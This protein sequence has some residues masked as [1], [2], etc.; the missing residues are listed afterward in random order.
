MQGLKMLSIVFAALATILSIARAESSINSSFVYNTGR[1]GSLA[2]AVVPVQYDG[3]LYFHLEVPAEYSWVAIGTGDQM[4]GSLMWV[5][6]RSRNGTGVTLSPR[7]VNGHVE[8]SYSSSINC[9]IL[10]S[11][12]APN[13]IV[14][15]NNGHDILAVNAI[16]HNI[17]TSHSPTAD[18]GEASVNLTSTTQPFIFAL[19]PTDRKIQSD[20]K[21]AG[22]RRHVLYGQF[23]MDLSKTAL[24]DS[25][26]IDEV[27]T[28]LSSVGNWQ[29]SN[30]QLVGDVTRDHDWAP[31][32]HGAFMCVTFV[33]V[34]PLG[35]VL[36]R[37][38]ERVKWHAWVQTFGVVLVV[39]G[40]GVGVYLGMQY[41]HSK[42]FN[43]AHQVI[44]IIVVVF[45]FV[46]LSIG[47]VHHRLYGRHGQ[48][49]AL[50]RIHR[51]VGPLVL[52]LGAVNGFLGFDFADD[53][54]HNV[55]YGVIV[56]VVFV[57]LVAALLWARRRRKVKDAVMERGDS[58]GEGA[59]VHGESGR[60]V[61]RGIPLKIFG[62]N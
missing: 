23:A 5:A 39:V 35:V 49:T 51:Y 29:N 53:G 26:P 45:T 21:T 55:W 32:T 60:G 20:S 14:K 22:I 36:L 7:T 54:G 62:R 52:I 31:A 28:Q 10:T 48:S 3:S 11:N 6:Y 47:V 12:T 37:L 33:L 16:C 42:N 34:F 1:T 40:L 8:P 19:G 57:A 61:G 15:A 43:S 44:G 58:E 46:Q 50:G 4:A 25:N 41:N 38:L 2:F 59:C 56:G 27:T 9:H 17:T 18:E 30:A 13:G 24:A